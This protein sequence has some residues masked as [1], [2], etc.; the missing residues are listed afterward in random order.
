MKGLSSIRA[1]L[2]FVFQRERVELDMEE[3]LRSH[4]QIRADYLERQ[5]LS[6]AEAERQARVEFGGY[7][8]YKEECREA[9]GT[10]LLGELVADL[11]YG[12]RQIRR[13]PGF[14]AV[15]VIT[16]ALGIGAN[17]AIFS[18]VSLIL[19]KK[20]PV[21][22]PD[23][24]MMV[25]SVNRA[26]G[27]DLLRVSAPNFE[28]FRRQNHVFQGMA[29]ADSD[30]TDF[31]LTG[32]GA[33]K[34]L[35]GLRVTTNYFKVL[36][37][38]PAMGRNFIPGEN[39]AGRDHVVILSHELWTQHFASN[40]KVIG[41]QV[42]IDGEPYTVIGV[43]RPGTDMPILQPQ[44]WTPI[45]FGP[46]SFG[47][48]AHNSRYL[49]VFARLKPGV[50]IKD[51]QAEVATIAARITQSNP[52]TEKG[53]SARVLPLQKYMVQ[54]VDVRA[55]LSVM[56]G[57]VMFVLLIAC[58][59]I[60]GLLLARAAGRQQEIAIRTAMGAGRLRVIRQLLAES[61]LI[62]LAGGGLG[63][64]L[65][66]WGIGLLRAALNWNSYVAYLALQLHLDG[67]TLLFSVALT[68][69][70]TVLFGLAPAL[71]ASKPDLVGTLKEGGRTGTGGFARSRMRS[72]LVTAEIALS[73][74]LL[75]GAGLF[76]LG[77]I[78]E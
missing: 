21:K 47:S 44:L 13:N 30:N 58:A 62:A 40:P 34:H 64:L 54:A 67:R 60:A 59:N 43:M 71:R 35:A 16:L 1:L 49:D 19:L 61:L 12:L 3:E 38:S 70:A 2:A 23:R 39:Q 73:V 25:V 45:V 68:A 10:R 7:Q 9:L 20:P 14:T 32:Q 24:L 5:G 75:A 50:T 78:S 33:P 69:G 76:I 17:T 15:A 36:G 18:T 29:A 72:L 51:T 65:G 55:S 53:W 46:K 27:W 42:D 22:D 31:T 26:K 52:E 11:R 57:A 56:M 6:H 4:L 41:K 37:L 8:R 74:V 28:S 77:F 66:L 63:L 48:S